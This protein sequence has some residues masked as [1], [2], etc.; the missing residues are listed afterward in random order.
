MAAVVLEANNLSKSYG[1]VKAVDHVDLTIAQGECLALLGPNGAGKTTT[2]EILEGLQAPTT[3]SVKILG[4]D[5]SRDRRTILESIGVLLQET[6]MYKKLTVRET[7]DLFGSFYKHPLSTDQIIERMQLE[8]KRDSRLE[9]LS[10]GQKQRVY[11]GCALIND[12][13]LVFLD[14]PTTGLDPQ[15]RRMIWN[16]LREYK[17]SERSILLTT[18]YMEE[19]EVLADRIAIMDH[20]KIIAQGSPRQLIADTCGEQIVWFALEKP[21]QVAELKNRL[22]DLRHAR[23]VE[24]GYEVTTR[25]APLLVANLTQAVQQM[26][27]VISSLQMRN[28]TL[29][30][31]FIKLTGRSIRD[32]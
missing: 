32:D 6:Y 23:E 29:E 8:E 17:G 7:L 12:P 22:S 19:A 30:D 9:H 13:T 25:T 20:G 4:K 16:L 11:I 1:S 26:G 24:G 5:I 27:L 15:A 10:G 31:V 28:S 3:G 21:D 2:V 14:E 18:H